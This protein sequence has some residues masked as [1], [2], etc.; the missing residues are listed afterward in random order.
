[1]SFEWNVPRFRWSIQRGNL[2][3]ELQAFVLALC[4]VAEHAQV[5]LTT[6]EHQGI[7]IERREIED[8][9]QA[10]GQFTFDRETS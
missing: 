6:I 10:V 3:P 2:R 4:D 1:M 9:E 8:L 7:D 5:L